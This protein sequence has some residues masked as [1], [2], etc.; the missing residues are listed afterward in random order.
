[1]SMILDAANRLYYRF[2]GH[3]KLRDYENLCLE[4]WKKQL[5]SSALTI[6]NKQLGLF[7]LVQRLSDDKLVTFHYLKDS[8]Y[9]SWSDENF[10][11]LKTEEICV[12]SISLRS[13]LS[14]QKSLI[15]TKII[16]HKGRLSS[17]EFNRAPKTVFDRN[18]QSNNIEVATIEVFAD[19][20]L[21][22]DFTHHAPAVKVNL[23][24]WVQELAKKGEIKFLKNPL[25]KDEQKKFY[26]QLSTK[27][28]AEYCELISQTEG[29]RINNCTIYGI[30]EIRTLVWPEANFYILAEIDDVGTIAVKQE[31]KQGTIYF[32][33]HEDQ[34]VKDAG[35]SFRLA[36]QKALDF[37]K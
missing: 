34:I 11:P 28:P 26:L 15:K 36:V 6:L 5:S 21:A 14:S 13:L 8:S 2:F 18:I 22:E 25:T 27:L 1:M 23:K 3:N 17:F 16:L 9:K 10:F 37:K 24:G 4:G 33:H 35:S 29:L 32:I 7:D 31:D 20:M 19:P 30:S 12:A